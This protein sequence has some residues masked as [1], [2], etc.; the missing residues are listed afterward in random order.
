[1]T[2]GILEQLLRSERSG[3]LVWFAF[4]LLQGSLLA[5]TLADSSGERPRTAGVMLLVFLFFLNWYLAERTLILWLALDF[6]DEV[7]DPQWEA[8]LHLS[9]LAFQRLVLTSVLVGVFRVA[10]YQALWAILAADRRL[11]AGITSL[12]GIGWSLWTIWEWFN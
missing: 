8:V 11:L 2:E 12:I 6:S 3:W 7:I 4:L 9:W 5:R 1:M 10:A